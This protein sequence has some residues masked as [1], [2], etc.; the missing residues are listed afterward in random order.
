L[1]NTTLEKANK[2]PK[3]NLINQVE[4]S[5]DFKPTKAERVEIEHNTKSLMPGKAE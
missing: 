3:N 4:P 2:L 5:V 1:K